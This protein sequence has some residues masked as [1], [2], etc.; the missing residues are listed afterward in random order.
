MELDFAYFKYWFEGIVGTCELIVST[1]AFGRKW[2]GH[3]AGITSIYCYDELMEQLLGDLHL[4]EHVALFA[5]EL[6]E[7]NAFDAVGAFARAA[8]ILHKTVDDDPELQSPEALLASQEWAAFQAAARPV[9]ELP[10]AKGYRSGR[11]DIDIPGG[12]GPSRED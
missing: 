5:N 10:V 4:E 9:I 2:L 8:L 7:W 12:C 3:E 6:G 11:V 1:D